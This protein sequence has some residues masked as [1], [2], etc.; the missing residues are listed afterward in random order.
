MNE[1]NMLD[2]VEHVRL[3]FPI[4]TE[5]LEKLVVELWGED[6]ASVIL[7]HY[8]HTIDGTNGK[9]FF[10]MVSDAAINC[11]IRTVAQRLC[12]SGSQ[13]YQYVFDAAVLPEVG[14]AH[15]SELPFVFDRDYMLP[16]K[17]L[18]ELSKQM[19][20]LWEHFEKTGNP[21]GGGLVPWKWPNAMGGAGSSKVVVFRTNNQSAVTLDPFNRCFVWSN[22]SD[23]EP[24]T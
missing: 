15:A 14:V 5:E 7:Q 20:G 24:S 21:N 17:S 22:D 8:N 10:A 6:K 23:G 18:I 12:H 2:M 1:S 19:V 13:V 4:S 11:P 16:T 9:A 3:L